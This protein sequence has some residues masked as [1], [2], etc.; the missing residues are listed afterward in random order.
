[1]TAPSAQAAQPVGDGRATRWHG[2]KARRRAEMIDAAVEV[3]EQHGLEISVQLIAEHL[4]LPRPVVY[5]HIGGRAELDALAR[6]RI[7][8]LLLAELLPALQPTGT[9]K[10]A[11]RG[12]VGTYLDWI[13]L[14]PNLHRFLGDAPQESGAGGLSGAGREVGG[15]LADMFAATLARFGIDPA[16][17][18]PMAFGMVGL[19]DGVVASW[20]A[21]PEP[22]LGAEQIQGIL[23]E[24]VL[25]LFEGNARSLGVPLQ[26]DSLVADL[27]VA[28]DAAP[29]PAERLR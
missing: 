29:P 13:E 18:R 28:P 8:E 19:V 11:V 26:R 16:R 17:A 24:S 3:I 4:A 1:M 10:D 15:Q 27:L 2:H 22:V 21:E 14:H 6:R 5:R 20:R 12:A 9:L 23:T 7:L 25:S